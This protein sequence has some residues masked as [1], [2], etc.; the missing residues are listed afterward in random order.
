MGKM[1][2]S[3]YIKGDYEDFYALRRRKNKA[4]QSQ[5]QYSASG[6]RHLENSILLL[7]WPK[8]FGEITNR[9]EV[10]TA[11]SSWFDWSHRQLNRVAHELNFFQPFDA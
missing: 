5:S 11:R 4:K 3:I 9:I 2:L 6:R 10:N 7:F 8:K 1:T